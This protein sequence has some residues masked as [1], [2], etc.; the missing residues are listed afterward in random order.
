MELARINGIVNVM[1][2]LVQVT[3]P[4][5]FSHNFSQTKLQF[6]CVPTDNVYSMYSS[7]PL[8]IPRVIFVMFAVPLLP[9][10]KLLQC[11]CVLATVVL[12]CLFH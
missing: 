3:L 9:P 7:L 1:N 4:I 12:M 6:S 2:A 5:I 10:L 11:L 8:W